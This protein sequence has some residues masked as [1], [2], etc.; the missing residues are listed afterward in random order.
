[1][2]RD[3]RFWNFDNAMDAEF[4]NLSIQISI[5]APV[6]RG[7]TEIIGWKWKEVIKEKLIDPNSCKVSMWP[8][9]NLKQNSVFGF[10]LGIFT[11][12]STNPDLIL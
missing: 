7:F 11:V 2:F 1:M 5:R 12:L 4:R 10:Q 8:Q 9:K 3:K 6:Y